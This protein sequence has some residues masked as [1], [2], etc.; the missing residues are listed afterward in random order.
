LKARSSAETGGKL[1][2]DFKRDLQA[3]GVEPESRVGHYRGTK[4]LEKWAQGEAI[5]EHLKTLASMYV[6]AYTAKSEVDAK[7]ST[8]ILVCEPGCKL[9]DAAPYGIRVKRENVN[10]YL[11]LLR[12]DYHDGQLSIKEQE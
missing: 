4:G 2:P 10:D 5:Q 6:P 9:T 7:K 8:V 3:I 1:T 11:E 12:C